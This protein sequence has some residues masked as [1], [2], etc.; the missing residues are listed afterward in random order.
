[1]RITIIVFFIFLTALFVAYLQTSDLPNNGG[2]Q[3]KNTDST[4]IT[5]EQKT[6]SFAGNQMNDKAIEDTSSKKEEENLID[7]K[8]DLSIQPINPETDPGNQI[9]GE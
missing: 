1:M 7:T 6:S 2:D 5:Y 3:E 8:S 9:I 4:T